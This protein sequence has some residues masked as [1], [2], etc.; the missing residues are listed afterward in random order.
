MGSLTTFGNPSKTTF[1]ATEEYKITVEATAKAVIRQGQ[2][3]KIDPTTGGVVIWLKTDPLSSLV[4]YAYG[5]A[6][7]G[8]LVTF[9]SRGYAMI[10]AISKAAQNAGPVSYDSY[11]DTTAVGGTMGYNVYAA[12]GVDAINGW[13]LDKATAANQL[14]R[15][16][17]M[18]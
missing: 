7:I 6:A 3:L 15:V 9:W 11:D 10:Y 13:A 16:L 8:E 12:A 2:P 18:D 5:N 4:G 1:L 14:I 17:L